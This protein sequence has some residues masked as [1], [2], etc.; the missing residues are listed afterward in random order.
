[1]KKILFFI[2][3]SV[4]LSVFSCGGGGG[5]S[6][7]GDSAGDSK[8]VL[9]NLSTSISQLTLNQ[10]GG[11]VSA[12]I[13]FDF[14]DSG[15]DLATMTVY[16]YARTGTSAITPIQGVSGITSGHL[17][18]MVTFSTI[19]RGTYNYGVYVTDNGGRPSN[20]LSGTYTVS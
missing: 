4:L 3:L 1:M 19:M 6:T 18:I 16:G 11:T 17:S 13:S 8:P 7:G 2:L 20:W 12:T 14:T 10:G 5:T 9:S 15:G